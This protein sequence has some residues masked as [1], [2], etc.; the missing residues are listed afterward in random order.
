MGELI[1]VEE[2]VKLQIEN[3]LTELSKRSDTINE[4]QATILALKEYA[5][6]LQTFLGS[7]SIDVE[8]E[9]QEKFVESLSEDGS[10]K[11]LNI[12]CSIENKILDLVSTI[13][14]FD[15]LP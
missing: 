13:T 7:K 6:D 10:L 3:L 5:S 4:I 8:V 12:K 2:N 11:Q 15:L 1:D 9:K 14:T